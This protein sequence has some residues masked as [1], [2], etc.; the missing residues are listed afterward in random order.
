MPDEGTRTKRARML[1]PHDDLGADDYH[2]WWLSGAKTYRDRA[3]RTSAQ[4][5]RWFYLRCNNP[6]C[7]AEAII[8]GDVLVAASVA[9]L[10]DGRG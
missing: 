1:T 3:G 4:T 10:E 2:E 8:R 6:D 5:T 9:A 7:G